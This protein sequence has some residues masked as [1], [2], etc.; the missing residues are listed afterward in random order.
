[1]RILLIIAGWT[2]PC[3]AGQHVC[4]VSG[5]I[6]AGHFTSSHIGRIFWVS[7]CMAWGD[8]GDAGT[9]R[10]H[11]DPMFMQFQKL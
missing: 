8:W 2:Q 5:V 10:E 1:M 11:F 7:M 4:D 3:G 9:P 6:I